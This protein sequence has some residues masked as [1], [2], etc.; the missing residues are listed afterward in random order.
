MLPT[1]CRP[2][3]PSRCA[4]VRS[5]EAMT[6]PGGTQAFYLVGAPQAN[7]RLG[8]CTAR[9]YATQ[10]PSFSAFI[11]H[12]GL[13]GEELLNLLVLSSVAFFS[14]AVRRN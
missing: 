13:T 12:K 5:K 1:P 11:W 10:P 2:Q 9:F 14:L 4:L 7:L 3:P 8:K 6:S